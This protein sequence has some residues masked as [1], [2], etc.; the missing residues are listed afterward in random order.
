MLIG[1]DALC[2]CAREELEAALRVANVANTDDTKDSM[3]AVHEDITQNGALT[4]HTLGYTVPSDETDIGV[5]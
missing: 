4:V 2:G 1:E 3:K 5:P